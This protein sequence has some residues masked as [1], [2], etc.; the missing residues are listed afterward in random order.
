[1]NIKTNAVMKRQYNLHHLSISPWKRQTTA[2]LKL[3]DISASRKAAN[4]IY[5][6]LRSL[7]SIFIPTLISILKYT[8]NPFW[9]TNRKPHKDVGFSKPA[10]FVSH[11]IVVQTAKQFDLSDSHKHSENLFV[12]TI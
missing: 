6:T 3:A 7:A 5:S 11:N 12:L 8:V 2:V 10:H 9:Y 1:M 4:P